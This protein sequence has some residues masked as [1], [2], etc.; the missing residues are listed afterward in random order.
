METNVILVMSRVPSQAEIS[1][2][3]K[4]LSEQGSFFKTVAEP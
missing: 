1:E 4:V 2:L 3:L